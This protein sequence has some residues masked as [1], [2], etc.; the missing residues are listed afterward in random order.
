MYLMHYLDEVGKKIYTLKVLVRLHAILR[1]VTNLFHTE[2][3]SN[4]LQYVITQLEFEYLM[5]V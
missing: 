1:L 3:G 5:F 4:T 2:T